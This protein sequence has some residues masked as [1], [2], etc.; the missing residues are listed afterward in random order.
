VHRRLA[1]LR[2]DEPTIDVTERLR[3]R[4]DH[5]PFPTPWLKDRRVLLAGLSLVAGGLLVGIAARYRRSL[6]RSRGQ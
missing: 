5:T 6:T 4:L 3:Y 1:L 2:L